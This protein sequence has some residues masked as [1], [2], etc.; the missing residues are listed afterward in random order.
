MSLRIEGSTSNNFCIYQSI[1]NLLLDMIRKLL[2]MIGMLFLSEQV[3]NNLKECM[4]ISKKI[5]NMTLHN[6][7]DASCFVHKV[8]QSCLIPT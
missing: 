8:A 3:R 4:L 7:T 5:E 6:K 1:G 2:D